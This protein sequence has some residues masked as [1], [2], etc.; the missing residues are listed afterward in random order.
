[1]NNNKID[2]FKSKIDCFIWPEDCLK[3]EREIKRKES[4][5]KEWLNI[6]LNFEI[7]LETGTLGL[8][9]SS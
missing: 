9:G 1:M 2:E 4:E 6:M 3:E 7:F 8:H 5:D